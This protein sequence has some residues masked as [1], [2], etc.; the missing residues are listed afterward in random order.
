MTEALRDIHARNMGTPLPLRDYLIRDLLSF[1]QRHGLRKATFP[2][3]PRDGA[4]LGS[5]DLIQTLHGL[6]EQGL[7]RAGSMGRQ[8]GPFRVEGFSLTLAGELHLEALQGKDSQQVELKAMLYLLQQAS[9]A[10]GP[11][12]PHHPYITPERVNRLI[13][14][15]IAHKNLTMAPNDKVMITAQGRRMMIAM[16]SLPF[17]SPGRNRNP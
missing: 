11:W 3:L 5:E 10:K 2:V 7:L 9:A 13:S 8:C 12:T 1:F 17:N 6:T 4:R 16:E 15:H 14:D